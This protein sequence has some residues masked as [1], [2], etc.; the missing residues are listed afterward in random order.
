MIKTVLTQDQIND[1]LEGVLRAS[2]SR[3]GNYSYKKSLDDLDS[4]M[5]A[6]ESAVLA[7]PEVVGMRLDAERYR[8]LRGMWW[9]DSPLCV[10]SRPKES[11]RLGV[12]CPTTGRLDA[13][14]DAAMKE[15]KP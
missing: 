6:I 15:Q 14:I 1:L 9:H 12:D 3:L 8:A 10:V 7:S 11:L 4:A 13:A 2:G 5:R